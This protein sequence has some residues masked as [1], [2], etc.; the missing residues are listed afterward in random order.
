MNMD[1]YMRKNIYL[2]VNS[3]YATA[4]GL[5]KSLYDKASF[6]SKHHNVTIITLNF[7]LHLNKIYKDIV[8]NGKLSKDVKIKY[9]FSDIGIIDNKKSTSDNLELE[10]LLNNLSDLQ[11]QK[12]NNAIR[13]FDNDGHYHAYISYNENN[14]I[15]F[16]D[17][18]NKID[19]NVLEKRYS[20]F[21]NQL[22][23]KD[24]FKDNKKIQQII[25]NR[26]QAPI[27][28]LWHKDNQPYRYFYLGSEQVFEKKFNEL[29]SDWLKTF[30]KCN[31][32]ILID[33]DF[34]K[35]ATLL[36]Q[37]DCEKICFIHSHQDYCNDTKF[38]K[39][40]SNFDKFVFLTNLQLNDF[41]TINPNIVKKSFLL[42]HPTI[43]LLKNTQRQKRLITISRLIANKPI[44]PA[45]KAFSKILND[46]PEYIY[47]IYGN[48][49]EK[50]NLE[51]LIK[52]LNLE[53]KVFLKGYT[54][55]ALDL[56]LNS[57]L[58]IS[59]TKFEGFGLSI[60]ESLS[61]SC[62]VITSNVKYGPS[63]MVIHSKNGFLVNHDDIDDIS[64]AIRSILNNPQEF[65]NNCIA[66]IKSNIT[67]T[68]G[69]SLLD[70]VSSK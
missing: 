65:Q 58:S 35:V 17:F 67:K 41:K 19:P 12:I 25:F 52:D 20:F 27:L 28:N 10:N 6:L 69:T 4:G 3:L 46:F 9:F 21:N 13:V 53:K 55:N 70:I 15:H 62:P 68:W 36:D 30:I 47:E 38:L 23:S 8:K 24:L 56:F 45:I 33:S 63:E 32:T 7:N 50:E 40:F 11:S 2:I 39:S 59:L 1:Y 5:T 37:V 34:S 54:N 61:M 29:L 42:P 18:M 51:K 44:A 66:S 22:I 48:G 31:D 43:T 49:S 64:N 60:L 16:I 14:D 26:N 57:E